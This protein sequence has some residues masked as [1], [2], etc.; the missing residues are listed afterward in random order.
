MAQAQRREDEEQSHVESAKRPVAKGRVGNV[1]YAV[2]D[3]K[4]DAGG[5][6]YKTTFE[7]SYKEGETWKTSNS[8]G[9]NELLQ[10]AKAADLAHTEV[11]KLQ[12]QGRGR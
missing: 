9:P 5:E 6:F 3:N 11:I 2:W 8:F 1:Q 12:A 4:T 10:L 7:L